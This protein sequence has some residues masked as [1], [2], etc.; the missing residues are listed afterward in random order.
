MTSC[1]PDAHSLACAVVRLASTQA[2]RAV[3]IR[4]DAIDSP[5]RRARSCSTSHGGACTRSVAPAGGHAKA[6]SL[7]TDPRAVRGG[8]SRSATQRESRSDNLVERELTTAVL[9]GAGPHQGLVNQFW[10]TGTGKLRHVPM[11]EGLY[12]SVLTNDLRLALTSQELLPLTA[13]VEDVESSH[14]L[15]SFVGEAMLRAL[16]VAKPEDRVALANHVLTALGAGDVVE[17]G[18]RQLLALRRPVAPGVWSLDVRPQTPLS[19]PALLTN[20]HGEPSLGTEIAAELDSADSVDLLCAFVKWSGLRMLTEPLRRLKERGGRLRVLTT[21]YIGATERQA[22]DRLSNDLGAE[23]RINYQTTSTRLHAKAWLFDRGSGYHTAYIGSSNLSRAALLDGLEWNVRLAAGSTPS[24][25]KKFRATFDSYWV[26]DSFELYHPAHDRDRLDDAL[27]TARGTSGSG[28]TVLSGLDVRPYPHQAEI[29][30]RLDVERT[31]HDRHRNL[32]VA[33]TGTGKTVVAALDYRRLGDRSL[34]FVAH[35]REIL[36]QSRA[37]Y[38]NVLGD[39]SFGELYVGGERPERWRHVFASVQSLAAY[40]VD[41]VPASHFDVVVLDESHHME[42]VSYRRLL[43]H[44]EPQELLALTATPERADGVNIAQEFFDGHIC[45]ELRLWDALA[46]DLLCPFHYFGVADGTDLSRLGWRRGEYDSTGLSNLYTG[47]DARVRLVVKSLVDKV[48]DVASMR[49]LGFCVSKAHASFMARR[50]NELG[51]PARAVDADTS[52]DDRR[53]A[54]H[55]LRDRRINALFAVDLFNEGLD[56]PDVDT[57]L[58]LRPTASATVFL[59]Q[60]GRGLRRTENKAVLTVLDFVG[61][62]RREYRFDVRYSALTGSRRRELVDQVN[63]GFPYLPAGSQIVLDRVT[64]QQVLDQLRAQLRMTRQQRAADVRQMGS[65][66]LA[67][68]LESANADLA[69]IYGSQHSW[70]ELVRAAGLSWPDP[71]PAERPLLR[72]IG[73]FLHVDDTERVNA[74]SELLDPDVCSYADMPP[75]Q[76]RYARMLF[77]CLWPDRGGFDSYEAGLTHLRSHPAVC[78]ELKQVFDLGLAHAAHVAHPL[79]G[80]VTLATHAHYRREELLAALDWASLTRSAR[81]N[82]TGVAW[83]QASQTDALMVN[84]RKS[85]RE[86]SPS[87]MYRDYALSERLFHWESQ[88]ATSTSSPAGQRYLHHKQ[89]GTSV[90][91][92][93][94]EAPTNDLG[95][96]PFLLLGPANYV[97][98]HGERPI[99]ITWELDHPIPPDVLLTARAVAS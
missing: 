12:E 73:A 23:V 82:V 74:Y 59:Q 99:A 64:Q 81:G 34:L 38:R 8:F 1:S 35:R 86:F 55:S 27:A 37:M 62:Q 61:Q 58:L 4:G 53:S 48:A 17:P 40:G 78:H 71:V 85:D 26:D 22:L 77:F 13:D 28:L 11:S 41:N 89:L 46:G 65:T 63:A 7:W 30:Q 32:V 6:G 2:T 88:N 52:P 25:F 21:T 24:L 57:L 9:S 76:Q 60:L 79:D 67:A 31:V 33:A 20:A 5:R 84:L 51:I 90:L 15:A 14:I 83:A 44:L 3:R 96:A 70:T 93:V 45:A 98:H 97:D 43:T 54:L 47:D 18:P 42:A 66:F 94:R 92:F 72:R 69:D 91:L 50:F 29:L 80:D 16:V 49:A 19:Q 95:T 56:L 75:R 68:Y 39:G 10:A 87:T 36:E